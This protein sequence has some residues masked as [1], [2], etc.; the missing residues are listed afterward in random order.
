MLDFL[1]KFCI[2]FFHSVMHVYMKSKHYFTK[3]QWREL[4]Y[5]VKIPSSEPLNIRDKLAK[6]V[7]SSLI[8]LLV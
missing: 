6:F 8:K 1:I 3:F 2:I 5:K 7:S 4:N